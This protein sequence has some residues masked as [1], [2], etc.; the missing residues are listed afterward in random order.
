MSP[1]T[2]IDEQTWIDD[3]PADEMEN[4]MEDED[5]PDNFIEI[6]PEVELDL[7]VESRPRSFTARQRIELLRE[8]RWLES[9]MEDFG[10]FDDYGNFENGAGDNAGCFSH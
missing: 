10:E 2:S 9:M 7:E 8:Q 3:D 1:R 6:E 5:F 4:D